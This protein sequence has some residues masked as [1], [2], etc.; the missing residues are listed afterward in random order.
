MINYVVLSKNAV[1]RRFRGRGSVRGRRIAGLIC[2]VFSLDKVKVVRKRMN[3]P[4][5]KKRCRPAFDRGVLIYGELFCLEKKISSYLGVEQEYEENILLQAMANFKTPKYTLISTFMKELDE[6]WIKQIYYRHLVL[7][8]EYDPL[9]LDKIFIDGTDVI[10]NAS[11]NYTINQKQVDATRLL[12]H[13]GLLHN[14]T[15]EAIKRTVVALRKKLD[16]YQHDEETIELIKTALK[17]PKIYTQTNYERLDRIQKILD[18]TG[19]KSVAIAFPEGVV[20]RSK[21]GRF[22]VGF[23]LQLL[24][25][26]NHIALAGYLLR[27]PNDENVMQTILEELKKDIELFIELME[28]YGENKE[29]IEELKNLLDKV[30]LICDSGYFTHE[31]IEACL[32][33]N[34]ELVVMSKQVAVQQNNKKRKEWYK[35]ICDVKTHKTD[36]VSKLLCIRIKEGYL[37]PFNRIIRYVRDYVTNSKYNRELDGSD[38]LL[39]EHCYIQ[40][41]EDCTGCPYVEK[42]GKKCNCATIKDRTTKFKY[43]T[44][45]EFVEGKYVDIYKDR[46]HISEGVNAFLKGLT[47]MF[48]VKGRNYKAAKIQV[49]LACLLHN[50]I[51]LDNIIDSIY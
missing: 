50:M 27:K 8:N 29:N 48:H 41:C 17:R 26:Q 2:Q 20:M 45:Q 31:N 43:L 7:I 30:T 11:I 49:I 51:R 16:E 5:E 9:K 10:A 19:S 12:H 24:M 18:E 46:I 38:D 22:D 47:G 42:Y 36:K 1:F 4:F 37:C 40:E 3:R 21:R 33:E 32:V 35:N 34:V 15:D 25:L 6:N 39:Y 23:N 13:W 44:T 28:T 14:G